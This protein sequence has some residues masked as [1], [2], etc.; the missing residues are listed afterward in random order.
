[1]STLSE[2]PEL[3][4]ALDA[5]GGKFSDAEMQALNRKVDLE[6]RSPDAVARDALAR[7]ELISSGAV[8]AEDPLLIATSP[9]SGQTANMPAHRCR[10]VRRAFVGPRSG[11][12][13]Q[14]QLRWSKSETATPG[15]PWLAPKAFLTYPARLRAA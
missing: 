14:H 1:M 11:C 3:G 15:W 9:H 12:P 7:L 6:G 5:L 10:A 8:A 2:F 4:G 13:S